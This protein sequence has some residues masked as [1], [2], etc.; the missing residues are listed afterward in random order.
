MATKLTD[1]NSIYELGKATEELN[2]S[3]DMIFHDKVELRE[4][5]R[6]PSEN[7]LLVAGIIVCPKKRSSHHGFSY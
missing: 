6:K 4:F 3:P 7:I 5:V 2:F 1:I